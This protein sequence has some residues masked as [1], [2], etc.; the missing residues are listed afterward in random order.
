MLH[1]ALRKVLGDHVQQKGSLVNEEMLRFDFSHF[2]GV[3]AEELAEVERLI[4]EKIWSNS[5]VKIQNMAKDE[6]VAAGAIAFFGEKYGDS[7][8]VVSVG[9]FSV[10]LCGGCH[11]GESAEIN[12]FKIA[13]EASIASGIRRIVGYTSQRAFEYL[14]KQDA[15]VKTLRDTYKVASLDELGQRL[16]RL[17]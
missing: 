12:L 10:E 4:N 9:D 3:T 6:A 13:S 5:G 16:E 2:Q 15:A 7:V 14:A 1:W 17:N 8:R 11:V